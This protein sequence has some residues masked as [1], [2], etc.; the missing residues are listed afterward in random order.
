[1]AKSFKK[2][3]V[4]PR[5]PSVKSTGDTM[6]TTTTRDTAVHKRSLTQ[7]QVN[8]LVALLL[9]MRYHSGKLTLSQNSI[10]AFMLQILRPR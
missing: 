1:M 9:E 4:S 5:S 8:L 6:S 10:I 3:S 2:K 7:A